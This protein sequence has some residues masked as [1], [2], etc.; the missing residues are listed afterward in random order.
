MGAVQKDS[1][2]Q[3]NFVSKTLNNT[4][5][6]GIVHCLSLVHDWRHMIPRGYRNF[7]VSLYVLLK[8]T[9]FLKANVRENKANM[10]LPPGGMYGVILSNFWMPQE[11]ENFG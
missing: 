8:P 7:A 9:Y 5:E 6:C 2:V 10:V 1:F 4:A 11:P 3:Y